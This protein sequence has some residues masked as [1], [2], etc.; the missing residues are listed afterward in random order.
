MDFVITPFWLFI[1]FVVLAAVLGSTFGQVYLWV[2]VLAVGAMFSDSELSIHIDAKKII[3][4]YMP[5]EATT[6]EKGGV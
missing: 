5:P 2:L 6:G 4:S 1:T 3:L